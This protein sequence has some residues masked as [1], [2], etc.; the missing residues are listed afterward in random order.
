MIDQ[1]E[2]PKKPP[3]KKKTRRTKV[4]LSYDH[5]FDSEFAEQFLQLFSS[6]L[7]FVKSK[8]GQGEEPLD[9]SLDEPLEEISYDMRM[10]T[11]DIAMEYRKLNCRNAAVTIVLI[12]EFSWHKKNVDWDAAASLSTS[13][14]YSK[15]GLLGIILPSYPEFHKNQY[16]LYTIPPRFADNLELGFSELQFWTK[17]WVKLSKWIKASIEKRD[18]PNTNRRPLYPKDRR[19]MRWQK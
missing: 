10:K 7:H 9:E 16:N 17:S 1:P 4:F 8:E 5:E 13:K 14:T 3:K 2:N 6:K 11:D 12:G 18:Q 19:G 15:A